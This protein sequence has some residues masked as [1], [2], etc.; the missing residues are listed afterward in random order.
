MKASQTGITAQF[1]AF[2]CRHRYAFWLGLVLIAVFIFVAN[3]MN[4][5]YKCWQ[6]RTD[7]LGA[8]ILER[9][10]KGQHVPRV[11]D[12]DSVSTLK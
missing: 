12:L 1:A 11:A 8:A 7:P 2:Y 3:A 10:H 9:I 4:T 6:W 5:Q